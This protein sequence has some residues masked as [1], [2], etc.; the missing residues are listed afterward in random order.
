VPGRFLIYSPT[1][2]PNTFVL[3]YARGDSGRSFSVRDYTPSAGPS[4]RYAT[5]FPGLTAEQILSEASLPGNHCFPADRIPTTNVAYW[6]STILDLNL[7]H[8]HRPTPKQVDQT[9][10]PLLDRHTFDGLPKAR[11]AKDVDRMLHSAQSEDWVT[12]NVTRLLLRRPAESWWGSV[13]DAVTRS[14]GT[15]FELPPPIRIDLWRSVAS[16]LAYE[17]KSRERMLTSDNQSWIARAGKPGPVE[18]FSEIDLAFAG[19]DYLVFVEAKLGAD[20]S[21]RTTYDPSRNQIVRNIDCVLEHNEDRKPFFWML[22][23]DRE[24]VRMYMRLIDTYRND[25]TILA[26]VV[27]HRTLSE[28]EEIARTLAVVTWSELLEGMTPETSEEEEVHQE[29]L[30]RIDHSSKASSKHGE[31]LT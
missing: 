2:A 24:P 17:T 26:A 11:K 31:L 29:I 4:I 14:T 27:P 22:A 3:L 10:F 6:R 20:I 21:L 23:K 30:R 18:G 28:L 1:L 15:L 5:E 12:W 25:P 16:P 13:L 8:L 7:R 19:D 9:T